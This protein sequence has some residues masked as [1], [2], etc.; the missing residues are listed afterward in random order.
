MGDD[1]MVQNVNAAA[2][3]FSV[4]R[5]PVQPQPA[6][7]Q[8]LTRS[9]RTDSVSFTA[10]VSKG[11][12]QSIVLE[13]AYE[14]LRGVV[15]EA[16]TALGIPEGQVLDTSPEATANRIADFALNFF[17]QYA[18]N[19]GLADDEE[20]RRQ[21]ADFIGGAIGKGIDEARGILNALNVLNPE[22]GAGIDKTA[23]LIQARLENFIT[24][25]LI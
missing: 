5:R 13:R 22:I 6:P 11:Q 19:N 16:R 14:Q 21:F 24:N 7:A 3:D 12:A 10:T 9:T 1:T 20:G 17:S 25:G 18:K 8:A 15:A 2:T 4:N 23:E